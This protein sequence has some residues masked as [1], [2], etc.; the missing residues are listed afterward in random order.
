MSVITIF[1]GSFCGEENVVGELLQTN[2]YRRILEAEVVS[3]AGR[4]SG[5]SSSS[6]SPTCSAATAGS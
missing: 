5:M 3:E 2:D 6:H 1:H 4:L